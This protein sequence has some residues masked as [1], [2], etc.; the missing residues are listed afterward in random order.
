MELFSR[1]A[2]RS[3]ILSVTRSKKHAFIDSFVSER[4]GDS[5]LAAASLFQDLAILQHLVVLD[6]QLE[7]W[8]SLDGASGR[9][10]NAAATVKSIGKWSIWSVTSEQTVCV[11]PVYHRF[12]YALQAE[13]EDLCMAVLEPDTYKHVYNEVS[14]LWGPQQDGRAALNEMSEA[15]SRSSQEAALQERRASSAA[16]GPSSPSSESG[17]Q[18]PTYFILACCAAMSPAYGI[19]APVPADLRWSTPLLA[20]RSKISRASTRIEGMLPTF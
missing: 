10:V 14:N 3:L 7:V 18:G 2:C 20:F 15:E 6:C 13:L 17:S 4:I 8:E 16:A 5:N 12:S 19:N 11:I 1:Q 9:V